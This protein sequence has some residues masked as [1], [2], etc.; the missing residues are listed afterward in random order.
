MADF[1]VLSAKILPP[2]PP[3]EQL[4]SHRFICRMLDGNGKALKL[5]VTKKVVEATEG[6]AF[7]VQM[8]HSASQK[9]WYRMTTWAGEHCV[10][11]KILPPLC[12]RVTHQEHRVDE[13]HVCPLMFA[14][15]DITDDESNSIRDRD[16]AARLASVKVTVERLV[17]VSLES[18]SPWRL[19]EEIQL[20][21]E[22]A[23]HESAKKVGALGFTSGPKQ[24]CQMGRQYYDGVPDPKF[25]TIT[26]IFHCMTR[27]GLQV[28]KLIPLDERED[29]SRNRASSSTRGGHDEMQYGEEQIREARERETRE[30]EAR[31]REA[32]DR[33]TRE[34]EARDREAR[35]REARDRETRERRA[36]E[37]EQAVI[38]EERAE[39]QRKV[40]ELEE[41]SAQLQQQKEGQGSST[42][43][44][45]EKLVFDFSTGGRPEQ[46]ILID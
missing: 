3:I 18:A 34:C 15:L 35:E 16:Y 25:S 27:V 14:K 32:R 12:F 22:Q 19:E 8:E 23:I 1:E 13:K 43:V 40:R 33:E 4:T 21:P 29:G 2:A 46:P 7:A 39:L 5:Y 37:Q 28:R 17:N 20:G 31:E 38:D 24:V 6:D 9:Q 11:G 10:G 26:F 30:R 41:R 45:V 36:R 44:K 42:R